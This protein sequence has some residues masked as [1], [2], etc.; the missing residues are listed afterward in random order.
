LH[1]TCNNRLRASVEDRR[2]IT[3]N[4]NDR[5]HRV[6][7]E[8]DMPLLWVL[9]D[10]LDLKGTKYGC[11]AG[12]C[13]ACAVRV[14]GDVLRSCVVPVGSV[15]G[16]RITTIEALAQAASLH[17]VQQAWL[18]LQVPQCGYCHPGIIMTVAHLLA[19]HPEPSDEQI[20][21]T[22]TNICRCSTYARIRPAIRAAAQAIRAGRKA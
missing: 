7:V 15:E 20:D 5:T 17:P 9:R 14:D 18:D 8:A 11:G 22:L 16:K 12:I 4:I 2:V 3:L 21:E 19:R 10:E 13:G 1:D 6:D